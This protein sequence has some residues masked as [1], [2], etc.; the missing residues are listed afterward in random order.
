MCRTLSV[1]ISQSSSPAAMVSPSALYHLT[2]V[3]SLMVGEREG[4]LMVVPITEPPVGTAA[5]AAGL[6]VA[7]DKKQINI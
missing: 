1:C 4:M 6:A 2:M 7:A 5:A 3:P